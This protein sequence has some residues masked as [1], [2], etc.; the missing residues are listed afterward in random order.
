MV[1]NVTL[2][3]NTWTAVT[4]DATSVVSLDGIVIRIY[5][6]SEYGGISGHI[7][8]LSDIEGVKGTQEDTATLI[9]FSSENI[10]ITTS[11]A[12]LS[13]DTEYR[14]GTEDGS[15]K[16]ETKTNSQ[17][18]VDL[19][20]N[21]DVDIRDYKSIKFIIYS[22]YNG[23]ESSGASNVATRYLQTYDTLDANPTKYTLAK[24]SWTVVT[25]E[26][27]ENITSLKDVKIRLFPNG[28]GKF[29]GE[30]FYIAD[31]IGVK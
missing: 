30:I 25:I 8:Y 22:S 28:Y 29:N 23:L 21:V 14:V 31:I 2:A 5:K 10:P 13:Y 4:I 18:Y 24:T 9:D 17:F 27:G 1:R 7:F 11:N 26:L 20:F 12:T 19:T 16:V 15:L 6:D 3:A